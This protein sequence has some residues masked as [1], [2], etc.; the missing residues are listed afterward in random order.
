MYTSQISGYDQT[1]IT[2]APV[3]ANPARVKAVKINN[4][5]T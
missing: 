2:F 1:V 4:P 3:C 5:D